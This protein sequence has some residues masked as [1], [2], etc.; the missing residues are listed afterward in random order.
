MSNTD[1]DQF[2]VAKS[3]KNQAC[4][5]EA[6]P[7]TAPL[8]DWQKMIV[9]WA[10]RTGRAALFED[11]GLGKT[12]QQLEWAKQVC[13]HT[14]GAVLILTPLAVAHQTRHE[15]ERFGYAARC[16]ET[17]ADCDMSGINITNYEKLHHF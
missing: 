15:A 12:L 1:Y 16:V 8:F 4:G 10:C 17:M 3:R 9:E 7:I 5:F 13:E 11:C 6:K 14:G 2:I